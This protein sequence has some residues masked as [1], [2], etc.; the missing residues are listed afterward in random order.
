MN[1]TFYSSWGTPLTI[2]SPKGSQLEKQI[3]E[4]DDYVNREI[5]VVPYSS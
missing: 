5:T 3:Q 2:Y 1:Y 4:L